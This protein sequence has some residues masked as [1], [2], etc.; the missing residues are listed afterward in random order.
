MLFDLADPMA[1]LVTDTTQTEQ[2][3]LESNTGQHHQTDQTDLSV[4]I[5]T[6]SNPPTSDQRTTNSSNNKQTQS[7]NQVSI[8]TNRQHYE[9][10]LSHQ[11]SPDLDDLTKNGNY[12]RSENIDFV[13]TQQLPQVQQPVFERVLMPEKKR[14]T[15]KK[16]LNAK[17]NSSNRHIQSNTSPVLYSQHEDFTDDSYH[18]V[19]H[20]Q[21]TSHNGHHIRPQSSMQQ[22]HNQITS[23]S[24]H[25]QKP[26]QNFGYDESADEIPPPRYVIR[27][28]GATVQ[29]RYRDYEDGGPPLLV[30]RDYSKSIPTSTYVDSYSTKNQNV[31]NSRENRPSKKQHITT[32]RKNECCDNDGNKAHYN[33]IKPGFVANAAKMWD[34]RAAHQTGQLNTIV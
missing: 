2:N 5:T 17:E 1:R 32:N 10:Q 27:S 29:N 9:T 28:N 7:T 15:V 30:I 11:S 26:Y 8:D 24:T 34:R 3:Y 22:R 14:P 6:S 21:Q 20:Y 13:Q 25:K 23:S 31:S 33:P 18:T 16:G 4:A 12:H 19:K